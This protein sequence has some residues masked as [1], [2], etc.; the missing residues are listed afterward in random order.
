M[1]QRQILSFLL[2]YFTT[3]IWATSHSCLFTLTSPPHLLSL[4]LCH[5]IIHIWSLPHILSA[6][7]LHPKHDLPS[8]TSPQP[9][10]L[11][12]FYLTRTFICFFTFSLGPSLPSS[13]SSLPSLSPVLSCPPSED[14]K[15]TVC[16]W[17]LRKMSVSRWEDRAGCFLTRSLSDNTEKNVLYV[18]NTCFEEGGGKWGRMIHCSK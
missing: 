1:F 13:P 16:D 10:R 2:H 9:L 15:L 3:L 11:S 7:H 14:I 18:Y 17:G 6:H 4:S 5:H 8:A 12:A